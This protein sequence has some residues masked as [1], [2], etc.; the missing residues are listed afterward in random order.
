[1]ALSVPVTS[2]YA[3]LS[4]LLIVALGFNVS[5]QRRAFGVDIGEG[6]R[7]EMLLAV[8]A[9]ANA[10]E[11]LPL[12]LVL[13]MLIELGGAAAWLLHAL[14]ASLLIGRLAHAQGLLVR[15]GG[16]SPGRF[17]GT[18]LTWGVLSAA[19]AILLWRVILEIR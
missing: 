8:R 14:G 9:H 13:L 17:I 6:Q 12:A 18:F 3:A 16:V 10:I 15:G 2:L 11:Y 5:R 19:A 7:P 4:A 1:M